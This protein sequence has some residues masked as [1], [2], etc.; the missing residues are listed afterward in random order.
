MT[1]ADL[2]RPAILLVEDDPAV[3]NAL[4]FSLELE[5]FEVCAYADGETL[6]ASTPLPTRGCLVLDYNLPGIDGLDLL[7]R[8][9]AAEVNLPAILITTNPRRALRAQ[10]ALAGVQII[11]KPL[12]TDALRD[13]VRNALGAATH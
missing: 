12:L 2:R 1:V 5:G 9:R 8:L 3:V 6:L 7:E 11:E 10:A 4:T 13:S